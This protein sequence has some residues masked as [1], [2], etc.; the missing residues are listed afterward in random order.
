MFGSCMKYRLLP[1]DTLA[2][3]GNLARSRM[4]K[5]KRKDKSSTLH[6][7]GFHALC[8]CNIAQHFDVSGNVLVSLQYNS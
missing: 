7:G 8:L 1:P 3:G 4:Q 6:T 2:G 5:E